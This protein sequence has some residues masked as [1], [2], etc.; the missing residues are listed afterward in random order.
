[1]YERIS[2]KGQAGGKGRVRQVKGGAGSP[3]EFACGFGRRGLVGR[4]DRRCFFFHSLQKIIIAAGGGGLFFLQARDILR[5]NIDKDTRLR[6]NA[7]GFMYA[8][9]IRAFLVIQFAGS[10]PSG[11]CCPTSARKG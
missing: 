8:G 3:I 7:N 4:G 5:S 9:F 6:E 1:M 2:W 11:P 10:I